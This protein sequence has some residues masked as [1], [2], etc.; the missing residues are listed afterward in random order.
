[1]KKKSF[2]LIIM[3][4]VLISVLGINSVYASENNDKTANTEMEEG[5][6]TFLLED[7]LNNKEEQN[8]TKSAASDTKLK[9]L[10]EKDKQKEATLST[11]TESSTNIPSSNKVLDGVDGNGYIWNVKPYNT[12][13]KVYF[14]VY[15]YD[16]MKK[17]YT[18]VMK[19]IVRIMLH[20]A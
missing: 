5:K 8:K 18:K 3:M 9:E 14:A 15:K 19:Q 10:L 17:K 20:I 1:M 12:S 2:F 16:I 13:T 7:L 11:Q 6:E 4:F